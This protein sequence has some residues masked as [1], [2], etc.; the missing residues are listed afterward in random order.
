MRFFSFLMPGTVKLG[1]GIARVTF[2]R[3]TPD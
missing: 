3:Y 1:V 2:V